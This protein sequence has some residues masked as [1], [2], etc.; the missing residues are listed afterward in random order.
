MSSYEHRVGY[1]LPGGQYRV[2]AHE[3]WLANDAM[4]APQTDDDL[5]H[6][7]FLYFAAIRGM[8]CTLAEFFAL[9]DATA[10]DGPMLGET[11]ISQT[12]PMR[13]D[14]QYDVRGHVSAVQ[15]K[16]SKR[17]GSMD[18]VTAHFDIVGPDGKLCGSVSSV[19]VFPRKA[20]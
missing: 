15:R 18:L 12:D 6:P 17:V 20:T 9:F 11:E 1:Q 16:T 7:M 14:E 13:V 4:C 3:R 8:G 10:D 5:L 19:F 2:L